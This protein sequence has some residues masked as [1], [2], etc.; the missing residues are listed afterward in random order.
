MNAAY[1]EVV[2]VLHRFYALLDDFRYADLVA[3]TCEDVR[4]QRQ[5]E[6]LA[7]HAAVMRALE[8]RS[9]ELLT[10]HVITNAFV[11]QA[12][13]QG[14]Q[15]FALM[16]AYRGPRADPPGPST[17]SKPFRLSRLDVLFR[18][19]GGVLKIAAQDSRVTFEFEGT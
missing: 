7:G 5:G 3:L 17:T 1:G 11:T 2:Q 10:T 8:R 15:V 9:T 13:E 4:W 14:L 12:T 16:T 19:V 6:L 18:R